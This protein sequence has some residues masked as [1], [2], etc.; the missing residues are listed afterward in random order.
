MYSIWTSRSNITH[1][2]SGY[3]PTKMMEFIRDMLQT[4]EL[5]KEYVKGN[6]QLFANGGNHQRM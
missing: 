4:L 5:P 6:T 1:G 2:E 3:N